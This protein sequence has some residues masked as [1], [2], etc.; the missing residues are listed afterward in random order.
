MPHRRQEHRPLYCY[1]CWLLHCLPSVNPGQHVGCQ[2]MWPSIA[3]RTKRSPLAQGLYFIFGTEE[4]STLKVAYRMGRGKAGCLSR[5][6]KTKDLFSISHRPS[7][8][9]TYHIQSLSAQSKLHQ[10][11]GQLSSQRRPASTRSPSSWP[12]QIW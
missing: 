7:T 1:T 6:L 2:S 9:Q 3:S 10:R 8:L 11:D 4:L 12:G 5:T